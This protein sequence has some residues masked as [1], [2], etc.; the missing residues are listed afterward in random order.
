MINYLIFVSTSIFFNL[1]PI[2]QLYAQQTSLKSNESPSSETQYEVYGQV[3]EKGSQIP[4]KNVKLFLLPAKKSIE[5]NE[6]GQ[7]RFSNQH[8]LSSKLILTVPGFKRFEKNLY[9][10]QSLDSTQTNS[11][12]VV[13][14]L[15]KENYLTFETTVVGKREK[16]DLSKK[17]MTQSEFLTVPGAN[18]DPVKAVQNLPGV[19]R[20]SGFS[21]SIIIQGSA[22]QDTKY[23][24]DG[25][26]IPIV[27]HFGGLTSVVMPESIK[28]V[29]Y[30]SAGYDS[31]YSRALGGI[32]S[33]Q[34]Y[35]P[36]LNGRNQKGFFFVDTLKSGILY[37]KQ[38]DEKSTL[39]LSGRYSYVGFVLKNVMKD[40]EQIDL[41]AAPDFADFSAIYNTEFEN[42]DKFKLVSLFSRDT[43]Q[44]V[45]NEPLQ[46]DPSI[47][48]S[49]KNETQFWRLI[50]QWQRDL[51]SSEKVKA[52]LGLGQDQILVNVGDNFFNLKSNA[53]TARGEYENKVSD[54]WLYQV[55]FDNSYSTAKVNLKL[56]TPTGEGGVNN[57][58]STSEVKSLSTTGKINLLGLYFRNELNY[59]S[60]TFIPS[61]RYD[62]YNSTKE[63]LI[64]PRFAIRKY[65]DPSLL[66]KFSS[67]LYYQAP[68]PQENAENFGNPDLKSSLSYH[69]TLGYE[70]DFR[71]GSID[72]FEFSNSYF[73]RDFKKLVTSSFD[74]RNYSNDGSGY[75]HGLEFMI[76]TT[77]SPWKGWLS[78]T[79]SESRR[80]DLT[81]R[82][83]VYEYDQTHN[84]NLVASYDYGKN[85][86]YS[87]RLRHV[88]GNPY[89]PISSGVFDADN[90]VY[91]PQRG[92]FFSRRRA[93]FN[94]LDLRIDKKL[95]Y[96]ESI[97]TVYLDIQ[98]LLNT[99]N[100]ESIDYSYDYSQQQNTT[101]L[102]L[103]P[104]IGVKGEF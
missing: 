23:N 22:P 49:F 85:W 54:T 30:L 101:G 79:L 1:I 62:R 18:G 25:H 61:I 36:N 76:K 88:T 103:L 98:N 95:I 43:L 82:N 87:A 3:L 15:E 102:P 19:N 94:Q 60:T 71:D 83:Y 69:Y 34:T 8:P 99:K 4:L 27:F 51:S 65:Y 66:L 63:D 56:P 38:L 78:Y 21:S 5:T 80:N 39:S 45:F 84:V 29:E 40:N 70:K 11:M 14:R 52:S 50:P 72:G 73:R 59:F 68:R 28:E 46:G 58:I 26:E 57:P 75:A 37:E 93:A 42:K 104:S 77:L 90:D 2:N 89:T 100:I 17:N 97:W 6:R 48:G 92:D 64:S 47:R 67:G 74:S 16:R 7:F 31:E 44:F 32:I 20:T 13:V 9:E 53:L 81:K 35:E 55:G 10:F 33:L 86:L 12:N 41:T 91:I 96:D 24:I